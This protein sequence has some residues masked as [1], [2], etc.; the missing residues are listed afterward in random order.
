M[1]ITKAKQSLASKNGLITE[2]KNSVRTQSEEGGSK[3]VAVSTERIQGGNEQ[4]RS[5]R[6]A[7]NDRKGKRL[8]AVRG[9]TSL[10][11]NKG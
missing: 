3:K 7:G 8:E 5:S 6:W 1:G 2:K 4:M 11:S 9:G 10:K